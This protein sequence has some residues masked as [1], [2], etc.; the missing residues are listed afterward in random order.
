[1]SRETVKGTS[2]PGAPVEVPTFNV[3]STCVGA[4]DGA[5]V[6]VGAGDGADVGVGVGDGIGV[7]TDVGVGVGDGIG[8]G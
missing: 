4:G 7:G 1:M 5:D 6:G 3:G 8:V 2:S